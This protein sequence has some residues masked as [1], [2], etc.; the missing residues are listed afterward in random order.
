[1]DTVNAPVLSV[2]VPGNTFV[3]TNHNHVSSPGGSTFFPQAE[4]PSPLPSFASSRNNCNTNHI[5]DTNIPSSLPSGTNNS[6]DTFITSADGSIRTN[7]HRYAKSF[8]DMNLHEKLLRGIYAYGFEKPS[9]IQ[10]YA[11]LPVIDGRDTIAQ[12]Q[13]GTGKT[14][15]FSIATLACIDIHD[16][17]CQAIL[18]APSRELAIQTHTVISSLGTNMGVR[19]HA[20]VGGT[21][22][23]E[24]QAILKEGIHI[25]VGTPGRTTYKRYNWDAQAIK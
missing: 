25:A 12:A 4:V 11:I 3:N 1:M 23:K 21:S 16:Q 13:S 15:T 2:S 19:C 18:L 9:P 6:T 22:V 14:G 17:R 10:S 5:P 8:D 20:L 24:D 7:Y